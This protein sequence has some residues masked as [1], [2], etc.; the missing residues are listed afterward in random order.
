MANFW[1]KRR[2]AKVTALA[3]V[4]IAVG[5]FLIWGATV[6]DGPKSTP[7]TPKLL[8]PPSDQASQP[9]AKP[10]DVG[11]AVPQKPSA[12]IRPLRTEDGMR[13][14]VTATTIASDSGRAVHIGSVSSSNQSGGITAGY[15]EQQTIGN[16]Q[17]EP[18]P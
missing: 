1:T 7:L 17:A 6:Q 18:E 5:T 14:A 15:I 4:A 3:T 12:N 2:A 16:D 8:A 11:E 9:A 10:P 13:E